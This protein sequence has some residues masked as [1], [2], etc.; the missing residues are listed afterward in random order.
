MHE[1][2]IRAV[3]T[4]SVSCVLEAWATFSR[5]HA[6]RVLED[7]PV[8]IS[9][10]LRGG[11]VRAEL[12]TVGLAAADELFFDQSIRPV[13]VQFEL[14]FPTRHGDLGIGIRCGHGH[15]GNFQR[16]YDLHPA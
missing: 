9:P 3:S 12:Q 16:Q 4:I 5:S 11:A 14:H 1:R 7:T 8:G 15:G 13:L 2:W 10:I 6:V